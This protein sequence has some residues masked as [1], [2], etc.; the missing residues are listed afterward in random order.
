MKGFIVIIIA[1]AYLLCY[2][3][4]A[5]AQY[6]LSGRVSASG[7]NKELLSKVAIINK[8]ANDMSYTD[9]EG[10]YSIIIHKGDTLEFSRLGYFSYT[11]FVGSVNGPVNRNIILSEKKNVLQ[12]IKVSGLTRYQRD[13]IER[14][15]TFGKAVNQQQVS[16]IMSPVTSLYQQFSKKYK[17]LRKFQAQYADMEKQKF[18]DT[19][20]TYEMVT[21]ITKLEG[22]AVAYFMNNYPMDYNFA[23]TSNA[24]EIK[25]WV[26]HNYKEY[27]LSSKKPSVKLEFLPQTPV[28]K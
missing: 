1:I 16:T 28:Q 17:D 20:Y 10:F 6:K 3:Q 21:A 15:N 18:I 4:S 22:D 14:T 5:M 23:R 7:E 9:D 11:Y 27:G 13:S 25:L 12:E 24:L 2:S 26:K 19:K 8:S